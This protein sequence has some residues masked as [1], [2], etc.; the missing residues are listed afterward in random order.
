MNNIA[1]VIGGLGCI[2]MAFW[3]YEH[4]IEGAGWLVFL[5]VLLLCDLKD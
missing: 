2:A 5:G 4:N 3:G 1:K